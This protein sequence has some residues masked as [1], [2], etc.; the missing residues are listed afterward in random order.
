M[1]AF[2]ILSGLEDAFT[3]LVSQMSPVLRHVIGL[4]ELLC[5]DHPYQ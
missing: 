5:S 2:S 4:C 3:T 1:E